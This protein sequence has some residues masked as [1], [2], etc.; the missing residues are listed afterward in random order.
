MAVTNSQLDIF[1]DLVPLIPLVMKG[2]VPMFTPYLNF[3]ALGKE[4]L[5]QMIDF[6]VNPAYI[7]TDEPSAKLQYTY[8]NRYFTTA[9]SDF[10][11]DMVAVY[12]WVANALDPVIHATVETRDILATGVSRIQYDNGITIY[13]NYRS[14]TVQVDGLVIPGLDYAVVNV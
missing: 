4:R 7:V 8:S 14:T 3:N 9:F 13:I 2:Y 11:E 5:L 1:T 10:K 12:Q 6:G